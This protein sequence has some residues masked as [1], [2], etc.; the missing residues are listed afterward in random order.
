MTSQLTYKES[1][2]TIRHNPRKRLRSSTSESVQ[3]NEGGLLPFWNEY[4]QE[5][6]KKWWL[7]ERYEF[8]YLF[9]LIY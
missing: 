2:E 7:P 8:N 5:E 9:A 6:L 3:R 4:T 1:S